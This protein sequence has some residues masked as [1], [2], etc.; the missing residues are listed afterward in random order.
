MQ[1]LA[2]EHANDIARRDHLDHA[3][4]ASGAKSGARAENV[5]YDNS[6]EA[7]TIG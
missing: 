1:R 5:A 3:G 7:A 4:L 2:K 6:S